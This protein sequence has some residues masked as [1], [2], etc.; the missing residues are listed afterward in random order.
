MEAYQY[1]KIDAFTAGESLG[2]PAACLYLGEGQALP[3]DR[4]LDIARRHRG[5]VSEVVYCAPAGDAAFRLWYYSSECEV[6][7]CGHGT[8]AC[9]HCLISETPGLQ[10]RA[11]IEVRT[12]KKGALTVYNEV[13][14]R[15]CVYVAAPAPK[16]LGTGVP[17]DTVAAALRVRPGQLSGKYPTDMI[18]AGLRTLIVPLASLEDEVH[19]APLESELK[20][21]CLET[22]ADIVLIWSLQARDARSIAHTRVFA[23]KFGYLEDPATGSGNSAFGYYMLQNG[24]W[25]GSAATLEQGGAGMAFNAV[26]VER[27]DGRVLFGG[28]ATTRI[29]GVYF[30]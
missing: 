8:V 10:E 25:D 15:D 30:D 3:E 18:D 27:R 9:M 24:L 22:G 28:G 26:R 1:R 2:N 5:F 7:F 13:P 21:F 6:D 19:A 4:M 14:S 12:N 23:P 20:A 16:Y 11:E 17:A 29:R